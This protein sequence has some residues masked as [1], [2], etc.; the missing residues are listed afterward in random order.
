MS[1]LPFSV[2]AGTLPE[3]ETTAFLSTEAEHVSASQACQEEHVLAFAR[4][5]RNS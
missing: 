1:L 4:R 3:S 5:F 2:E